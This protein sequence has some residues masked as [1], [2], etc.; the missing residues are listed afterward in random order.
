[1]GQE[2]WRGRISRPSDASC[3]SAVLLGGAVGGRVQESASAYS[4]HEILLRGTHTYDQ[5]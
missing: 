1:M 5:L 4:V 3:A 2:A